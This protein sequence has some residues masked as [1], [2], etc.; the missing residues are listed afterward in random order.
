MQLKTFDFD[1]D[2]QKWDAFVL[3]QSGASFFHL[4]NWHKVIEA[5]YRNFTPYYRYVEDGGEWL[6]ILPATRVARPFAG[7]ALISNP[8]AV[9]ASILCTEGVRQSTVLDLLLSDKESYDYIELRDA[10]TPLP[11]GWQ[12]HQHFANF[13]KT[14]TSDHEENW[15]AIPNRQRAVIRKAD[16]C[17]LTFEFHQDLERFLRVYAISLRNLGTP[18]YP[19]RYFELLMSQFGSQVRIATVSKEGKDLTTVLCFAFQDR[20]LPYY[21]GGLPDARHFHAY[22]WMYWQLMKYGVDHQLPTFDFGRSPMASG[23]YAFKKNLG[24]TP[25]PLTY[26]ALPIKGTP[27]DLTG[28]SDVAKRLIQVWQHLPVQVTRWLGPVGAVYAV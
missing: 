14:L 17:E 25:R 11:E 4:A 3:K 10:I 20:L 5:S 9:S 18:I 23:P 16:Q 1:R 22:P 13:E 27:P 7:T 26:A 12:T 15:L 2:H 8:F 6:A 24:F 21:G 28:E 19:R